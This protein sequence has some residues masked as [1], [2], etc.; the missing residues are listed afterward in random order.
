MPT[1]NKNGRRP[2]MP[3]KKPAASRWTNANQKFYDSSA[4]KS[5]RKMQLDKFPLCAECE[6]KGV[7]TPGQ[8][9]DHIIPMNKGGEA[10]SMNN[11]QTLCH[12]CHNKKS[13]KEK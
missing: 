4:W 7:L 1:I 5:L 3:E 8:V 6:K 10:L 9:V 11:L 13:A 12:R 2:W